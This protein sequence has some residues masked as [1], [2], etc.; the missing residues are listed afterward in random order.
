MKPLAYIKKLFCKNHDVEEE[1]CGYMTA[2]EVH[3][4]C[5]RR[6]ES[7]KDLYERTI[8]KMK[9]NPPLIYTGTPISNID[10]DSDRVCYVEFVQPLLD[11]IYLQVG[12]SKV[13]N[14]RL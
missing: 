10:M 7:I 8:E 12:E 2:S 9:I 4:R 11:N 3:E 1:Y 13:V 5:E 14:R 6:E